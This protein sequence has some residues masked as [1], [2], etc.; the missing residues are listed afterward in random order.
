MPH[1]LSTIQPPQRLDS[2]S[3]RDFERELLSV[4]ERGGHFIVLDFTNLEFISSAGL[5]VILSVAKRLKAI[6]GGL[7]ICSLK[8]Y[9][10]EIF[11]TTGCSDILD[12]FPT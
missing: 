9:V 8:W 11:D 1:E 5:R 12:I 3:S 7:A 10:K 2:S 6:G 4:I